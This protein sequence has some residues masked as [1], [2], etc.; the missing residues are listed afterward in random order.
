[1]AYLDVREYRA[2]SADGLRAASPPFGVEFTTLSAAEILACLLD[3]PVPKGDDP[4]LLVTSNVDHIVRLRRDAQFRAA[5]RSAWLATADGMPVY[6]YAR[7]RQEGIKGRVTGSDLIATLV[8]RFDPGLHRPFFICA[9]PAVCCGLRARLSAN[10]FDS[11]A[12]DFVTPPFGFELDEDYSEALATRIRERGT[13]HLV[14]G[15][16]APK[17]EIWAYRHRR[18]LGSCYVLPV[19]AGLEYAIGLKRR[20]PVALRRT[21]FEWAWRLAQEPRRL[22]RRYAIDS[23]PFLAAMWDDARGRPL[24]YQDFLLPPAR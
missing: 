8:D 10:G 14:M 3:D 1:L 20:A 24:L 11:D 9:D 4:R 23:W 12:A 15:V 17:S 6:L 5:Y 7:R 19:G 2:I 21:G 13:T 18:L 22:F 16:G